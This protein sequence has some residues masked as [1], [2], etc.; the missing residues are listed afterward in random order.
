VSGAAERN[1]IRSVFARRRQFL[2]L[3]CRS[4]CVF[5]PETYQEI[6]IAPN[7][8]ME[9]WWY[10]H[11]RSKV[12]FSRVTAFF[13]VTSACR[14]DSCVSASPRIRHLRAESLWKYRAAVAIEEFGDYKVINFLISL[15]LA[16]RRHL[17]F[18]ASF[19]PPETWT[20]LEILPIKIFYQVLNVRP[21]QILA[22]FYFLMTA[23]T[24]NIAYFSTS[25][26]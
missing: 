23:Q 5:P 17:L 20:R 2:S 21:N 1:L 22:C 18:Y 10:G 6:R 3:L 7:A 11:V 25:W 9:T 26:L 8:P 16:G 12:F 15:P 13:Q 4:V 19:P 14:G 24:C